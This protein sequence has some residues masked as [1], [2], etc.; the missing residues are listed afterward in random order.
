MAAT[1]TAPPPAAAA[2]VPIGTSMVDYIERPHVVG[3]SANATTPN[4]SLLL[5]SS[6]TTT[7]SNML[8]K[9]LPKSGKT[10]LVMDLVHSVA[11]HAPCRGACTAPCTCVAAVLLRTATKSSFP[12]CCQQV[13]PESDFQAQL[14]A[15][16]APKA[17]WNKAALR[18]I[19]V[20]HLES[21]TDLLHYLLGLQGRDERDRPSGCIVLD[22]IESFVSTGEDQQQLSMPETM[23]LVQI[24]EYL[25]VHISFRLHYLLPERV[26]FL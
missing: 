15:L 22:D 17:T 1:A 16:D 10:S 11:T 14:K 23:N 24:S 4:N 9:G 18:R 5:P 20:H 25:W 8:V 6:T 19:Q 3:T 26:Y 12:L 2:V 7:P 21:M 13:Q